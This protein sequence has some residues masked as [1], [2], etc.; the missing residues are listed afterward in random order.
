MIQIYF[1]SILFN[2]AAGFLLFS[3]T[4]D[5]KET[6]ILKIDEFSFLRSPTVRI[7]LGILASIT[8]ILKILAPSPGNIPVL[9]DILPALAGIFSGFILLFEFFTRSSSG[10]SVPSSLQTVLRMKKRIG[11]GVMIIAALHLI[12]PGALLL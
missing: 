7:T 10:A 3:D 5:T 9:G 6:D 4:E 11:I 2:G 8:G 12:F 1:F